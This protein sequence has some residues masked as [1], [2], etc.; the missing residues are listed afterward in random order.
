L[1]RASLRFVIV[2]FILIST[3]AALFADAGEASFIFLRLGPGSR[4][5][6]LGEAVTASGGEITSAF[7]NPALL[8]SFKGNRQVAFMYN[9]YFM[10]VS[11]NYLSF[12][13]KG[14]KLAAG[15]YLLLGKIGDI[16]RRNGPD[17]VANGLFDENHFYGA[18]NASYRFDKF[19]LGLAV[20]Y[21]YEKI[22]YRSANS[23]MF[24]FGIAAPLNNEIKL[25]AAVKNIGG[26]PEF[27]SE[28]F[29]LS[30]EYRLGVEYMPDFADQALGLM[31]DAVFYS[32]IDTKINFGAE[33]DLHRYLTVRG[34]Y[35]TGYDSRGLS[36]G[37]G[38]VYRYFN[39]DYAFVGF[40]NDL[41]NAHRFTL[42]A[43][44]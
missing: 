26:E 4:P 12:A 38:L 28:S 21:A 16:E 7:Y 42:S 29:A 13:S 24:D 37:G 11:Q 31:A 23:F 19:D 36:L 30:K 32:D 2:T 40:K 44:F 43:L 18:F 35:G 17:T 10:D 14:E 5:A 1:I 3:S 9:S 22:D 27:I 34:G 41:G 8:P 25:G 6:A 15:M 33:Y 20:K 39:F